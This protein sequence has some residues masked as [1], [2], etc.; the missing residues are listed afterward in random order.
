[1][2]QLTGIA[3]CSILFVCWATWVRARKG[4]DDEDLPHVAME[5]MSSGDNVTSGAVH[6]NGTAGHTNSSED[7]LFG[8]S[9][10]DPQLS[11]L[12]EAIRDVAYYLR[13]YK[14]SEYDR[15][16]LVTKPSS[17]GYFSNFPK[18]PLR[19]LHWEV[20]KHCDYSFISCME[21][22]HKQIKKT[23]HRRSDDTSVI[24]NEQQWFGDNFS[25]QISSVDEDCTKMMNKDDR[26]ANPFLG[27]LER[28]QWRTTASYFLCWYTMNGVP[29]LEIF[30][31]SCDNFANCL[32][33]KFGANNKDARVIN[34]TNYLC[35]LYSVCP[36]PC[37]PL[38]HIASYEDCWNNEINPCLVG[39]EGAKRQCTFERN[40]NRDFADIVLNR[41]NVTC[42]CAQ[43]G[44]IWES[45]FGLCVDVNECTTG[46]HNC[47][48]A[49]EV[50]VNLPGSYRCLCNWGYIWNEETNLCTTS[51]ALD[52]IKRPHEDE[53]NKNKSMSGSIIKMITNKIFS[54]SGQYSMNNL[55]QQIL[56]LILPSLLYCR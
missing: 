31:E 24:I 27:P 46:D 13:A 17:L 56:Y 49:S 55:N 29:D 47:D 26:L 35:I 19:S 42:A 43:E 18:P 44:Y 37:C 1:M 7:A 40:R 34:D 45:R 53:Y 9:H 22:L 6:G 51:P 48:E 11:W 10:G 5:T 25:Q 28:F 3:L 41:W 16:Y 23:D 21:F 36:D 54:K 4:A 8:G 12:N 32:D 14:F 2:H 50:C 20:Q 52:I 33:T 30:G 15:R 39:N 38:R